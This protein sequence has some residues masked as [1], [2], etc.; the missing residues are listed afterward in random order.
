MAIKDNNAVMPVIKKELQTNRIDGTD[1][2]DLSKV[3]NKEKNAAK[4]IYLKKT[5]ML[6]L[7][8]YRDYL[9]HYLR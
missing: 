6:S 2:T 9:N 3:A 1:K 4:K 7:N 5:V 8:L